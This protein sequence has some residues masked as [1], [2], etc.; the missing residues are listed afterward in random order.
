MVVAVA[1]GLCPTVHRAS[2]DAG[3]VDAHAADEYAVLQQSDDEPP[4]LVKHQPLALIV[5][6]KRVDGHVALRQI[7]AYGRVAALGIA[8]GPVEAR[9]ACIV[10]VEVVFQLCGYQ[11]APHG[12]CLAYFAQQLLTQHVTVGV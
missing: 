12:R 3:G 2:E 5:F 9:I 11:L 8:D 7:M 10:T 6:Q 4:L 1:G